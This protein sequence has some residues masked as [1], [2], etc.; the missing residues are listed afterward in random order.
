MSLTDDDDGAVDTSLAARIYDT[1]RARIILGD[2][3]QGSRLPEQRLADELQVSRIPL[4]EALSRLAAD[5]LVVTT[6]RRSAVVSSWAPGTVHDL[7]D[8][9]LALETS[10]AGLAARRLNGVAELQRSLERSIDEMRAGDELG[11]AEANVRFHQALVAAA[12]NQ[13]MDGLMRRISARMSWLFF[14]TAHRDHDVACS[15]HS[16]IVG[17]VRLG[18]VRLAETLTYA[19]IETGREPSLAAMHALLPA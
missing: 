10:A 5:G 6:H 8:A 17:A 16:A 2:F 11:I 4:R 7:F 3:P 1:V 18:N 9:R 19:H 12:G 15:E 13:L 14:L